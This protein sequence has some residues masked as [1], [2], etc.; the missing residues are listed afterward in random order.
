[1]IIVV[2]L[3]KV[4][5]AKGWLLG[6]YLSLLLALFT[7]LLAAVSMIFM[8]G[9]EGTNLHEGIT[10]TEATEDVLF[11][12]VITLF[13]GVMGLIFGIVTYSRG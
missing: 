10:K 6:T 8:F 4:K 11:Y 3:A 7:M 13:F 12:C 2:H 9:D 1:M 5:K